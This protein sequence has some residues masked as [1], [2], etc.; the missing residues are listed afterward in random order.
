MPREMVEA[1]AKRIWDGGL[2]LVDDIFAATYDWKP[3]DK[4]GKYI[5]VLRGMQH[6]L[7]EIVVHCSDP[8]PV[9]P[10]FTSMNPSCKSTLLQRRVAQSPS[11]IAVHIPQITIGRMKSSSCTASYIR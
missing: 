5:E 7:L 3:E 1:I 11:R 2:P 4:V 8:T 6:G 10:V 9:F